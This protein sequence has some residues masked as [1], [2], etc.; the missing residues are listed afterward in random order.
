MKHSLLISSS[1]IILPPLSSG[2]SKLCSAPLLTLDRSE[3]LALFFP[4]LLSCTSFLNLCRATNHLAVLHIE[5][6]FS[7][8]L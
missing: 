3:L 1:S 4:A 7:L 8:S 5:F 2:A 6:C